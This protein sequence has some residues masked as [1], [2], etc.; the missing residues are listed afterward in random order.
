[1][2]SPRS[3]S[4]H[5]NYWTHDELR[6]LMNVAANEL[7]CMLDVIRRDDGDEAWAGDALVNERLDVWLAARARYLAEAESGGA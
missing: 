1:M 7:A 2:S 3:M 6:R 5:W 4:E